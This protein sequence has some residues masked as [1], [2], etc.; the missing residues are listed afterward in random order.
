MA[1]TKPVTQLIT[2]RTSVRTYSKNPIAPQTLESLNEFIA[3][4]QAGPFQKGAPLRRTRIRLIASQPGDADALKGLGTYGV[5]RHPAGFIVAAMK[6]TD[7]MNLEDFGY[8]MEQIILFATDL[9]LGTCWL[10]GSFRQSNFARAIEIQN[11][12][13]IPAVV[14]IGNIAAKPSLRDSV[15]RFIAGSKNRKPWENLF[16]QQ[17]FQTPLTQEMAGI[18]ATPLEMLRLGP[19]ASNKQ[20]WRIVKEPEKSVFHFYLERTP[21]YN[22]SEKF[23]L[24]VAD[25]QRMDIGI[26]LCHFEL[27]A[28][29]QELSG[30]WEVADPGIAPLSEHTEYRAS[31]IG[32]Q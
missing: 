31:W 2:T 13:S 1:F 11:D 26:A 18:Y 29:E 22:R 24:K 6:N 3:A 23:F 12:E 27:T 8:A 4:H 7:R 9:N 32:E 17:N 10:G 21:G 5:I 28:R 20:P 14:S 16:F 30:T 25:L 19:S 15:V